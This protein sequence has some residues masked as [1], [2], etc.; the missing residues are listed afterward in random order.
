MSLGGSSATPQGPNVKLTTR[1][2]IDGGIGESVEEV[3]QND[4]RELDLPTVVPNKERLPG[5]KTPVPS[6]LLDSPEIIESRLNKKQKVNE[7]SR[8]TPNASTADPDNKRPDSFVTP[9]DDNLPSLLSR[10]EKMNAKMEL[11]VAKH[12]ML[13]KINDHLMALYLKHLKALLISP[14]PPVEEAPI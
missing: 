7:T 8:V 2:D 6:D 4:E 12:K 1:Y 13:L 5:K 14:K 11:E 3:S 10:M 9:G